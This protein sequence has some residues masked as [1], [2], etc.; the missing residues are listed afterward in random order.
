MENYTFEDIHAIIRMDA[1]SR[2][3]D[4]IFSEDDDVDIKKR[5]DKRVEDVRIARIAW[6]ESPEG[7]EYRKTEKALLDAELSKCTVT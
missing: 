3:K 4:A 6:E 5:E 7:I 1:E 2:T